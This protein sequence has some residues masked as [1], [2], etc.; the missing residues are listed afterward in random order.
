MQVIYHFL[1]QLLPFEW[2]QFD[3]MK[4]ALLAVLII[5]PLFGLT[6][7][8]IVNNRMSFFSDALGH[9]A[10]TGIAIG[11]LLGIDNYMFS[12]IGFALLFALAISAVIESGTTSADTVIGV[13]SSA[14]MALGIVLLSANGGFSKYSNYLIGDILSVRPNELLLLLCIFVV[15]LAVWV[16]CFNR[17]MIA[18]LNA[19]L[20][21]SKQV[22]ARLYKNLFVI[23]IALIVAVSIKWVGI[24][25]IN[26]L[27]VLPAAAARNLARSMRS[28][29]GLSV[30]ISLFSGV[31]GLI[32]SYYMGTAAGGTIVLV[33]AA[34][35]FVAFAWRRLRARA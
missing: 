31:S 7:T 5:T 3:F 9:S 29:H 2:A 27:L 12:M 28:Y 26:S 33:A 13:F 15:V 17:L 4:N 18:S 10:L 30:L 16:L 11:V 34:L 22:N 14:G 20:A 21:A 23:L 32:L 8:M 24:L 35:F 19:D 6:G 1:N 25:I